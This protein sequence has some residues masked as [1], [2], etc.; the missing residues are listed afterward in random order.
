M[1]IQ[2]VRRIAGNLASL[3]TSQV[4]NRAATFVVYALVARY[5]GAFEFGQL[6]LA[7]TLFSIAETLAEMGLR[8]LVTREVA[9]DRANTS[10]YFV[11]GS[12]IVFGGSLL[13]IAGLLVFVRLVG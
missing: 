13:S 11:N 5:L 1:V 10:M 4:V 3:L 2:S 8:T 9:R 12:A 7:F 6:T